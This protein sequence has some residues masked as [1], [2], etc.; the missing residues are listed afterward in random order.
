MAKK[1]QTCLHPEFGKIGHLSDFNIGVLIFKI[2][3]RRRMERRKGEWQK[4][5]RKR[6]EGEDRG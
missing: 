5:E 6:G 2:R 4:R 1:T 3:E